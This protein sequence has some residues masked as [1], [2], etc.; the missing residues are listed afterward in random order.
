META[1]NE[2]ITLI[3]KV[4]TLIHKQSKL[5]ED[6]NL[7]ELKSLGEEHYN[8]LTIEENKIFKQLI[9]SLGIFYE[10]DSIHNP[11]LMS[12][13]FFENVRIQMLKNET[14]KD[15]RSDGTISEDLK[16]VIE[17]E[18]GE[19]IPTDSDDKISETLPKKEEQNQKVAE[20]TN[21]QTKGSLS[22]DV[23]EEVSQDSK[24]KSENERDSEVSSDN[25]D[26]SHI[27]SELVSAKE[28]IQNVK[29][30]N[31]K[32]SSQDE[33]QSKLDDLNNYHQETLEKANKD[34]QLSIKGNIPKIDCSNKQE[35]D[36]IKKEVVDDFGIF[37][38]KTFDE[39]MTKLSTWED[40]ADAER[41]RNYYQM[42]NLKMVN[43][44]INKYNM[45]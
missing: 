8:F 45:E 37:L 9:H 35:A 34:C 36:R 33:F 22:K 17:E 2:K 23:P 30:D 43:Y 24:A 4:N 40:K 39:E 10:N 14:E 16:K 1:N 28:N 18:T 32:T 26:K 3:D 7:K 21:M 38:N 27:D 42:Y 19:T 29:T 12:D 13:R 15:I 41:F 11:K 5:R 25:L 44:L 6:S 20:D 31:L